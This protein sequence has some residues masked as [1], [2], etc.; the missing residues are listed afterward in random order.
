MSAISS[1]MLLQLAGLGSQGD[2]DRFNALLDCAAGMA[3]SRPA[4][5]KDAGTLLL[6]TVDVVADSATSTEST[7]SAITDEEEARR[8]QVWGWFC[9]LS[10]DERDRVFTVVDKSWISLL[11]AMHAEV[12]RKGDGVFCFEEEDAVPAPM[13]VKGKRG[14]IVGCGSPGTK[15]HAWMGVG[16]R[17]LL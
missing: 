5:D 6:G 16:V 12:K 13:P 4:A 10:V 11:F 7:A 8:S 9:A 1:E 3:K 15:F 2:A 14:A 17:S